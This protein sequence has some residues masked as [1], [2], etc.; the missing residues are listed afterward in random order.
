MGIF[1]T[2][3]NDFYDCFSDPSCLNKP[4]HDIEI[5]KFSWLATMA[6]E[7]GTE[8]QKDV[9]RKYYGKFGKTE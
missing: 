1:Y 3:Q 4:G 2:I 5:G 8:K 7:H 6:M 9:M